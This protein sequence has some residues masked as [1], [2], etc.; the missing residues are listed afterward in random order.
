MLVG[1][2]MHTIMK[3]ANGALFLLFLSVPNLVC[4]L[5]ELKWTGR[6][7]KVSKCA[8]WSTGFHWVGVWRWAYQSP[9]YAD[10]FNVVTVVKL[11]TGGHR[12]KVAPQD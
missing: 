11:E 6:M 10:A 4:L 3:C 12:P 1:Y 7:R 9:R 2:Q 8:P 5:M